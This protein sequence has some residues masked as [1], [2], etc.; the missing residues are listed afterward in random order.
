MFIPMEEQT[1]EKSQLEIELD[2]VESLTGNIESL[3]DDL[4]TKLDPVLNKQ[5]QVVKYEQEKERVART[6][7]AELVYQRNE[8]LEIIRMTIKNLLAQV[9]L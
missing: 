4:T 7:L 5:V 9:D 1:T 2:R 8:R 6:T 3:L